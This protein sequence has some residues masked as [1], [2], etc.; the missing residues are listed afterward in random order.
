MQAGLPPLVLIFDIARIGPANH[1]CGEHVGAAP[2]VRR[3]IELGGQPRI[4]RQPDEL[5]VQVY[6][7]HAVRR[8]DVQHRTTSTPRARQTEAG[9]VQPGWI[10]LGVVGGS[11]RKRHHDVRVVRLVPTLT[12]PRA[13]HTNVD[14]S[15]IVVV[16]LPRNRPAPHAESRPAGNATFRRATSATVI[17]RLHAPPRRSDMRS[18]GTRIGN[19]FSA[20]HS[21]I[22][23]TGVLPTT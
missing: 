8:A 23:H 15:R 17:R 3:Q 18:S 19:R 14:P 16:R 20:K 12:H 9:A 6:Q 11:H 13:R 5:A 7:Q 21:G 2:Q 4:L 22:S 1:H 10:A